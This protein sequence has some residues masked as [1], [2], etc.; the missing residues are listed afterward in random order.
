MDSLQNASSKALAMLLAR[1]PLSQAKLDFAWQAVAGPPAQRATVRV[2]LEGDVLHV[3]VR[4]HA[5]VRELSQAVATIV[6][7]LNQ[8]LGSGTVGRMVVRSSDPGPRPRGT[9]AR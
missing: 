8:L 7:R 4:D 1:Q 9:A 3:A 2:H 6:P 5:W